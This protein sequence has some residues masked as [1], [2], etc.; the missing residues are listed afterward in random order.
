MPRKFL[1]RS[2]KT[3]VAGTVLALLSS[4]TQ[5]QKP[6]QEP[7]FAVT[8]PPPKQELRWSNGK[9]PKSLDPARAAA[10]PESD[11]VRAVFEGLTDINARTYEAVPA[12]AEKWSSSDD[13]RIW[14]FQLRRD[15]RWSNGKRVTAADFESAW[16]RLATLG[17]KVAHRELVQNIVGLKTQKPTTPPAED[18]IIRDD[19]FKADPQ[20]QNSTRPFRPAQT[21]PSPKPAE[22]NPQQTP[23]TA[24]SDGTQLQKIGVEAVNDSTLKVTLELPDKDFPKL[25]ADPIFRPVYG[26]GSRFENDPLDKN[27]ITNGAFEVANAGKDGVTLDRSEKYWN[28]ADVELERIHFV[29]KD[30]AEAALDAYKKGEIDAITNADFEPLALKLLAPYEDFRKTTHGALNYYEVNTRN[31]PFGDRRVREALAIAIDRD[32]LSDVELEG[33]TRPAGNFLPLNSDRGR[34]LMLDVQKARDLL[35]KAGFASGEGFPKI[36]LVI[37]RNDTQQRVARAVAKMWKDNLNVDTEV[38]VKET[39]EIEAVRAAGEYDLLRRGVVLPTV[40]ELVGLSSIFGTPIKTPEVMTDGS[41][42]AARK[43]ERSG[44][45]DPALTDTN[46]PTALPTVVLL[47][48]E[49]A[50]YE[51]NAVPLYF[52]VS[53]SLVKPYVKGFEING[54]DAPSLR[55]VSIDSNWQPK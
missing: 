12:V 36:R 13:K 45:S 40:D 31:A 34:K 30:T 42:P 51:L 1:K 20:I 47:T 38:I 48:E 16:K 26:D 28:K 50:L 52:P 41:T 18:P 21:A 44:P 23:P 54:L 17:D 24:N 14:T 19:P 55:D 35:G 8:P 9:L 22:T 5:I 27:V 6:A 25:V 29:P 32:R 15:A 10:A 43:D 11:I 33:A 39:S 3:L 4:C 37:N 7:F 46:L 2:V 49:D 53:Y